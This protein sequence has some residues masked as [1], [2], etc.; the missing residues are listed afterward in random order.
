MKFRLILRALPLYAF[1]L[2]RALAKNLDA[3]P[4]EQQIANHQRIVDANR[5]GNPQIA[6]QAV[7]HVTNPFM[8]RSLQVW[9]R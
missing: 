5:M 6:E 1:S 3:S 2:M 4:W 9:A 8:E 7:I